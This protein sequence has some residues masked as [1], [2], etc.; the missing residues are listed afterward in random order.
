[1]NKGTGLY[2]IADRLGISLQEFAAVG[3]SVS[4]IPMFKL[5]GFRASV[6]NADPQ[7]SRLSQTT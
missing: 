3:D 4:D 5:A 6:G 7:L 2:R 1:V